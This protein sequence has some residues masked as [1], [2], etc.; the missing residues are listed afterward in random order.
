M[1]RIRKVTS[2]EAARWE[3]SEQQRQQRQMLTRERLGDISIVPASTAPT[4]MRGLTRMDYPSHGSVG[5]MARVYVS[6]HTYVRFFSDGAHGGPELAQRYAVAWRD[7]VRER[8]RDFIK[9]RQRRIVRVER[10]EHHNVGYFA[11]NP[12]GRRRYFS[13]SR[14]GGPAGALRMAEAWQSGG[15]AAIAAVVKSI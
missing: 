9:P 15:A 14:Y 10:P 5:W 3:L 11:W 4:D 8:V 12:D 2:E 6:D 13:D 7:A 1:P